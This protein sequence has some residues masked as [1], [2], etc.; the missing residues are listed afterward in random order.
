M[1]KIRVTNLRHEYY[2][3]STRKIRVIKLW[4]ESNF[5][6]YKQ[7]SCHQVMTRILFMS[8]WQNSCHQVMTRIHVSEPHCM[9][10]TLQPKIHC[11]E[12]LTSHSNSFI[13]PCIYVKNS[14]TP[15]RDVFFTFPTGQTETIPPRGGGFLDAKFSFSF[16]MRLLWHEYDFV[17]TQNSCRQ[18]MTRILLLLNAQNSCHKVM[19]GIILLINAQNSCHQLATRILLLLNAQNSCHQV[20]TRIQF[21]V[22]QAKFV[23]PSYDTNTIYEQLAKFVSSSYDTNTCFGT[24]LHA[25]Y[26]ATKNTLFGIANFSFQFVHRSMHMFKTQLHHPET[27]VFFTF[28]TGQ[29]ETIPPRGGGFLDA[30]FSFSF[31]MRLSSASSIATPRSLQFSDAETILTSSF[32]RG[33]IISYGLYTASVMSSLCWWRDPKSMISLPTADSKS[34]PSLSLSSSLSLP[35]SISL[36]SSLDSSSK[37]TS[38]DIERGIFVEL[39]FKATMTSSLE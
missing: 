15:S 2:F 25:K 17:S 34:N 7:N 10:N 8:N 24:S 3:C 36:K 31:E 28:P 14:I 19:T 21:R 26:A 23:S 18:I 39:Y 35:A 13:V 16:E 1:R 5:V 29:T 32:A 33:I 6:Y 38:C 30:K 27:F 22:L 37:Y 12:L 4:H 20:M 9:Q 11:L